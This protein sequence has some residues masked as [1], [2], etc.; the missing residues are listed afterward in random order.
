MKVVSFWES[1]ELPHQFEHVSSESDSVPDMSLSVREILQR[2]RR[3]T[4]TAQ[5]VERPYYNDE[6]CADPDFLDAYE[7]CED[8]A[9]LHQ[10]TNSVKSKITNAYGE[11]EKYRRKGRKGDGDNSSSSQPFQGE[12]P[13]EGG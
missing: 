4:L 8:F 9:D 10:L 13:E 5:D 2:F 6:D 3:G 12:S 7:Q 11:I 1:I